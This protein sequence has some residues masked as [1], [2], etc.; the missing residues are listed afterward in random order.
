[1]SKESQEKMGGL[2]EAAFK[3]RDRLKNLKRKAEQ[4]NNNDGSIG[5]YNND[6]ELVPK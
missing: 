6:T 1:M 3:R 4:R 2:E 5:E